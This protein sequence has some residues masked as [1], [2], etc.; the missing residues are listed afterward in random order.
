[1]EDHSQEPNLQDLVRQIEFSGK[2]LEI[3]VASYLDKYGWQEVTNTDTFVDRDEGKLRDID[4]CA[5]LAHPP[6]RIGNLGLETFLLF[7]CKND[8]GYAWV[9]FTRPFEFD[10]EDIAGQYTDEIQMATRNTENTEIMEMILRKANLHYSNFQTVA[11]TYDRILAHPPKDYDPRRKDHLKRKEKNNHLLEAQNQLKKCI[12]WS[13]DQDVRKRS[14]LLPYTIEMY[15]PCILFQGFM[16]EAK[17][18]NNGK[19]SLEPQNHILLETLFR[20]PY[21]VYEKNVLID[22]VSG[23]PLNEKTVGQYQELIQKDITSLQGIMSQ[24]SEEIG[25]RIDK[26]LELIESTRK[27]E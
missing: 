10:T 14:H 6:T 18:D 23:K 22:V 5:S 13:I 8:P 25:T 7:E 2:P 4:I 1:M 21:S 3:L 9:F 20:S 11:V 19:V 27:T 24:N 26:I 16:Y 17:I 15:F 12:D